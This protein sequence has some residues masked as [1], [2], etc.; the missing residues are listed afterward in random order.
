MK[1]ILWAQELVK[2]QGWA[3]ALRIATTTDKFYEHSSFYEQ[4]AGWIK[5]NAPT[6]E[7][8]NK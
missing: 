2:F 1:P 3:E 6:G 4:A 5:K 7:L 8:E